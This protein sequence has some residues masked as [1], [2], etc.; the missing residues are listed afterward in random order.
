MTVFIHLSRCLDI[1]SLGKRGELFKAFH[2]LEPE[3]IL[4][5]QNVVDSKDVIMKIGYSSLS[6]IIE[7]EKW[8]SSYLL[9]MNEMKSKQIQ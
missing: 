2:I 3:P 4:S 1:P 8:V 7:Q 6:E 9:G 5:E